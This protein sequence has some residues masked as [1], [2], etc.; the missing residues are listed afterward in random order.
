MV[1]LCSGSDVVVD[2]CSVFVECLCSTVRC[3]VSGRQVCYTYSRLATD[4]VKLRLPRWLHVYGRSL[5][6]WNCPV[7]GALPSSIASPY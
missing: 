5:D 6:M 2:M 1:D 4:G 3:Y 7:G